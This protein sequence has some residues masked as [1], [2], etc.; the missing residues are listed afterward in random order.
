[1]LIPKQ[2]TKFAYKKGLLLKNKTILLMV[3]YFY[4]IIIFFR[5]NKKI[6]T[7]K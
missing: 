3:L 4:Q 1:M 5:Y 7:E 6:S 2:E